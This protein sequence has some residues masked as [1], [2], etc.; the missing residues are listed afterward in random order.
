MDYTVTNI[1]FKPDGAPD[2]VE[3]LQYTLEVPEN[4]S[5]DS[6]RTIP[7]TFLKVESRS[8][9][10]V[11]P[12]IYLAGG[13]G[14]SGITA[15]T[16][17]RWP[18]FERLREVADVILLDQRGT[19]RSNTIPECRSSVL[20]PE[21]K[22]T[23]RKRY[24]NLYRE[25]L[26]ECLEFWS[27]RQVDITGYTSWESAADID[28][29]RRALGTDKVNLPGISYGT[30]LALATLKRYPDHIDRLV[31]A[32]SEGLDQTVKLPKLTDAYFRRLQQVIDN[33]SVARSH[34]PVISSMLR[35]VLE[36]A[37]DHPPVFQVPASEEHAAFTYTMGK[38][39]MQRITGYQLGDPGDISSILEGYLESQQDNYNWF[40]VYKYYQENP[41]AISFRGMPV[42]ME[43]A[44]GISQERLQ[45]VRRQ[46][47]TATLGDAL[48][49][50][51]PHLRGV[52]PGIE[53]GDWYR[54]PVSSGRPA[55]FISGTLDGR[56]YP[57]AT[58]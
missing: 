55:L 47:E 34:Y 21:Y 43:L 22:P 41:R 26:K 50:P 46:A 11:S 45:L 27:R 40:R 14:G 2:S 53:L 30:H 44:S 1:S 7:V 12:I 6:S 48:N 28:A 19:G 36:R 13:P 23:T 56:T 4:R 42:V 37:E 8:E 10:P 51:M 9:D 20:L 29:V 58:R 31:M 52:I 16:D 32:S 17:R 39:E 57:E 3:A 33:D 49:F 18:L 15:A 35:N 54:E 5:I 25:A 38:F 24:I